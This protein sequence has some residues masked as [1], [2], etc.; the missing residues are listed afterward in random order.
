MARGNPL[1]RLAHASSSGLADD[2]I[3]SPRNA[4]AARARPSRHALAAWLRGE[5]VLWLTTAAL[6]VSGAAYLVWSFLPSALRPGDL[7]IV[8]DVAFLPASLLVALLA[9]RASAADGIADG[10]RRAWLWIGVAYLLFWSGDLLWFTYEVVLHVEPSPS[11]ADLA[12]L[13]YYPALV[14]GLVSF[15][16]VLRTPMERLRFGLDTATVVLGGA[17]VAWLL[18]IGP[19]ASAAHRDSLETLLSLAYPVGDLVLLLGVVV[20]A[21]R[22]P[23]DLPRGAVVT[24]ISGLAIFLAA[25]LIYGVQ[26]VDASYA[27]GGP[28]DAMN[29]IAWTLTGIAAYL[30]AR[31]ANLSSQP[32]V[33]G[34]AR[35]GIP[36]VPYLGVGVGYA[37][38]L[39]A[40][41]DW[42]T[43]TIA[44]LVLGAGGL[45]ALLMGRQ[46][47]DIKENLR[48]VAEREGRRAD[49]RLQTLVQ[50]ASDLILLTDPDWRI[51]YA[52]PSVTRTL[53]RQAED[54]V[55]ELLVE[56]VHAGD[57]P[58]ANSLLGSALRSGDRSPTYEL[59]MLRRDGTSCSVE[60]SV[61][62]LVDDP[63]VHGYV[64]TIRD[65][66]QRK[67]LEVK[68]ARH[69]QGHPGR[70]PDPVR[71][72]G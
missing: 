33:D 48:L 54:V 65:I 69:W 13:A 14:I 34:R 68:L 36:L 16:R 70:G 2:S 57:R 8:S 3:P 26:S 20:M 66:D 32:H 46:L 42:W 55:G 24:L 7:T 18:V 22:T 44:G 41:S 40:M 56:L 43:P 23:P 62:D 19:S 47:V 6:V 53:G 9:W 59:R 27:A 5:R 25:D 4:S 29:V 35:A 10:T 60:V 61:L 51:R 71:G 50:N 37:M 58:I 1:R 39:T 21:L 15:P 11:L 63:A 38:L 49:A 45:T 30:A 12:Y 31:R 17:M 28:V 52:T 67:R 64:V 72:A